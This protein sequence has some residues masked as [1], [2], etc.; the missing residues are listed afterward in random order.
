MELDF[1]GV[2][3][4]GI[5]FPEG[6]A[7]KHGRLTGAL[8]G[9]PAWQFELELDPT[10]MSSKTDGLCFQFQPPSSY[11]QLWTWPEKTGRS[12]TK[13]RVSGAFFQAAQFRH[14]PQEPRG[15]RVLKPLVGE[16]PESAANVSTPLVSLCPTSAPR[17]PSC[18][19]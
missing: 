12:M 1:K 19:L 3:S 4:L 2:A 5:V 10:F 18:R 14:R 6:Q 17:V 7:A 13:Q 16:L 9:D 8:R 11:F 15:Q